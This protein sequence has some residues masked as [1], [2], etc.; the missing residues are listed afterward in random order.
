MD[1][2]AQFNKTKFES[3]LESERIRKFLQ[4]LANRCHRDQKKNEELVVHIAY[5]EDPNPY[6]LVYTEWVKK[7]KAKLDKPVA[8]DPCVLVYFT[9]V[10]GRTITTR[11][12]LAPSPLFDGKVITMEGSLPVLSRPITLNL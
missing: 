12:G 1:P 2:D 4:L 5:F 8:D 9:T 6:L 7:K 3:I 11:N 10:L